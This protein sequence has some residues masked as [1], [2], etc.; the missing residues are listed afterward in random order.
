MSSV[1]KRKYNPE[2]IIAL[3]QTMYVYVLCSV[4]NMLTILQV[5]LSDHTCTVSVLPGEKAYSTVCDTCL[6]AGTYLPCR[7]RV[8]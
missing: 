3:V 8:P 5:F 6:P 4:R 2:N 1:A 7:S